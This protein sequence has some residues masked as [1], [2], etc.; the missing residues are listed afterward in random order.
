MKNLGIT[1]I[2][3][4]I[5]IS[6]MGLRRIAHL[7]YRTGR[8]WMCDLGVVTG[9]DETGRCTVDAYLDQAAKLA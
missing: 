2:R 7:T 5:D 8:E 3:S 1:T 9:G 6:G 4:L